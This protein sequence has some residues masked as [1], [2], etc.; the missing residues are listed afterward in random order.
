MLPLLLY[1]APL[2][3]SYELGL[4]VTPFSSKMTTTIGDRILGE[5]IYYDL[6]MT[7]YY[8]RYINRIPGKV[9]A[10]VDLRCL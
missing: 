2:C 4:V 9:P 8:Y 5:C 7:Q 1:K 10:N 3:H 6:W